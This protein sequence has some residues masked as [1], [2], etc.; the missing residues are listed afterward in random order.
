M[1]KTRV[2]FGPAA[3]LLVGLALLAGCASGGGQAAAPAAAPAAA[4][5]PGTVVAG[6]AK[7]A[8][9][10]KYVCSCGP[11]CTCDTSS[12]K[13]GTCG[14]GKPLTYKKVLK[15]DSFCYWVCSCPGCACD[16]L[17]KDDPF[18]C[19]CG[20]PLQAIAKK[21]RY[22]CACGA[23]CDCGTVSQNPGTCACGKPLKIVQ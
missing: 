3:T 4:A 10:Y 12:N 2:G 22:A 17:S 16:A 20:K 6:P 11:S 18:K 14:C 9:G 7:A 1:V 5:K 23:E 19:G 8:P 13:P 21:G 15:E